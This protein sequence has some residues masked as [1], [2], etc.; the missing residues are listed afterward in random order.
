M[1]TRTV[2]LLRDRKGCVHQRARPARLD[3][4]AAADLCNSFAHRGYADA[5]AGSGVS[6]VA[7]AAVAA[8]STLAVNA[9]ACG[10]V[11]LAAIV[12]IPAVSVVGD[13]SVEPPAVGGKCDCDFARARMTKRVGD[14]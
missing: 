1:T 14:G 6:T 13:G 8:V 4:Q 12:H 9:V 7:V 3:R 5:A 2:H 10:T 11:A